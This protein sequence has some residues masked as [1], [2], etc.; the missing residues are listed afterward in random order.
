VLIKI[1]SAFL[2]LTF[3]AASSGLRGEVVPALPAD[4]EALALIAKYD[5][6]YLPRE[7]GYFGQLNI[8][9]LEV[10]ADG[11]KL[12]AHSSIYYLLTR[13]APINYLHWL[14]SDDTHIL[15]EGGPV[16]YLIFHPDGK[17]ER[18]I[19]GRDAKAGQTLMVSIPGNCWKALRLLPE[20][21]FALMANVLTPQWTPKGVKIGAGPA[22]VHKYENA[23]PWATAD[24]LRELI[25]PNWQNG[26]TP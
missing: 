26:A 21:H 19:L 4:S 8:S 7:S 1:K 16:E 5:L 6:K 9:G 3:C 17:V 2:V 14:S 23:A 25:G 15:L 22:F 11:K 12:R 18:Q 13:E 20:A 24:F 10:F